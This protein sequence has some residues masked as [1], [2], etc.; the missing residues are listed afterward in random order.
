MFS[1]AVAGWRANVTGDDGVRLHAILGASDECASV[2]FNGP[3]GSRP[4]CDAGVDS[5]R[6][7]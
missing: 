6:C 3:A 1:M 4:R 2:A 7:R 5:L